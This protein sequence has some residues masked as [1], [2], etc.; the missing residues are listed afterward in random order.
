[1]PTPR[2]G[3]ARIRRLDRARP[4]LH[5]STR[6]L[7]CLCARPF[8]HRH[9]L[10]R[11]WPCRHR[12]AVTAAKRRTMARLYATRLSTS[13]LPTARLAA[14][15]RC[16]PDQPHASR[17]G[18]GRRSTSY[19][20]PTHHS[21]RW[22]PSKPDRRAGAQETLPH[23]GNRRR[24]RTGTE[25]PNLS[26]SHVDPV[27]VHRLRRSKHGTRHSGYRSR[28]PT[29]DI[30]DIRHA[31]LVYVGDVRLVDDRRVGHVDRTDVVLAHVIAGDVYLAGPERKP[32]DANSAGRP[33]DPRD[34]G[35]RI[36]RANPTRARHPTPRIVPSGPT[37]VVERRKPPRRVID[38][39]PTPRR[40]PSPV[41]K[42]VGCPAH[43]HSR[44][45]PHG[46]VVRRALPPPVLIEVLRA[47]D[48]VGDV[49]ARGGL[50][51][52]AVALE[53][54]VVEAVGSPERGGGRFDAIV[55]E[56]S[57]RLLI[58]NRVG[59]SAAGR[60]GLAIAHP[61]DGAITRVTDLHA[62][63]T[64]LVQHHGRIGCVDLVR[65]VLQQLTHVHD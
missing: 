24:S 8:L 40:D 57:H 30:R 23:R 11:R 26:R 50:L 44:R 36:D 58:I 20:R 18:R 6:P 7:L 10:L 65:L 1:G 42:A 63:L 56:E 22:P 31:V 34:H 55:A 21:L 39:C 64:G 9:A 33:A 35:G 54:P 4:R 25:P 15:G 16:R 49:L 61:H 46:T 59:L 51:I 13:N 47:G 37:A 14:T 29:I 27:T 3:R 2:V 17:A 48:I 52:L 38:P 41:S 5:R 43:G 28:H 62:V 53:R 32:A 12:R 60:F 45:D 19:H